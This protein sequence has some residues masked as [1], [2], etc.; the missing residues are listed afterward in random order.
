M[1]SKI[2]DS[3]V[4]YLV[5]SILISVALWLYVVNV[6]NPNGDKN[7]HNIPITI[8]G[9][10]LL[11]S[12]GLMITDMSIRYFNLDLTGKRNALVKL[13]EENII[14]TLDVSSITTEGEWALKCKVTLPSMVTSGNV[15]PTEKN[16]YSITVT[17]AKKVSKTIDI[18][19]EFTGKV[20][21][22]Y[23]A[24]EF[25]IS[26]ATVT[27]TGQED[28]VNQIA[29]GL[30]TVTQD[31]LADTFTGEMSFSPMNAAN[32]KL[33]DLN[34]AYSA[35]TVYVT[36]PIVKVLEIP[37][38]VDILDGGGATRDNVTLSIIPAT[39][40]VSGAEEVLE[41]LKE[42]TLGQI[43]LAEV[44]SIDTFTFTIPLASE[45][46][47]ESGI[48]EATVTVTVT[49]LPSKVLEVDSIKLINVPEGYTAT[50]VTQSLQVWVR[51]PEEVLDFITVYNVRVV[52]DLQD[53]HI[54]A[55]QFRVP[56]KVY[57]DG[58]TGGGIVGTDYTIAIQVT[59]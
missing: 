51:G 48:T 7:V 35:S 41:P 33:I 27:I 52:A 16:N 12:R 49:G 39:I 44:L 55:G 18:R 58:G 9:A 19:G 5:I 6:E 3:K 13:T 14:V 20:A 2:S 54:S 50:A 43:N 4:F 45:L 40:V 28:H 23:Q 31:N 42:I 53:M 24:D 30:V 57:L 10:D 8:Q 47:N 32:E 17:I 25:I 46:T 21:Q 37:L 34:A 11:E 36:L 26:P 29:Y 1:G 56:V 38:T 22:G 59:D 15:T